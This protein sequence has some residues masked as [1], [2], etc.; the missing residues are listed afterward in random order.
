MVKCNIYAKTKVGIL[1][2]F[3]KIEY[4]EDKELDQN[5]LFCVYF[6]SFLNKMTAGQMGHLRFSSHCYVLPIPLW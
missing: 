3:N 4:T 5:I 2:R 1:N 6:T